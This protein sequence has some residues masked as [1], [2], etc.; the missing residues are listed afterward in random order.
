MSMLVP[1]TN[2]KLANCTKIFANYA[3]SVH[4]SIISCINILTPSFFYQYNF[5]YLVVKN[6]PCAVI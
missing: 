2:M 4:D 3:V 5:M 1:A 6:I